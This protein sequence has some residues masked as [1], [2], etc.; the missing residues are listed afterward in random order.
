LH[1]RKFVVVLLEVDIS[2][3][4]DFI[5]WSFLFEVLHFVGF[6]RRWIE[7]IAILLST[8]S[9]KVLMNGRVGPQI[10]HAHGLR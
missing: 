3:A 5:A 2:K 8:A 6:P 4:F 1:S 7:W 10:I 9:T